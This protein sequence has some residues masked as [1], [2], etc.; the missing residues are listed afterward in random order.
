MLPNLKRKK[1][2]GS[3]S[4]G[5][6][7]KAEWNGGPV[8]VKILHEKLFTSR[9]EYLAQFEAECKILQ[10]LQ[11]K[12]VV[13][14][15]EF[16]ISHTSPPML[17]TELLDCDLGK[18]IANCHPG[19]IPYSETVSIMLDVAEGLAYLHQQNPPI[20]HRDL[21]SKN[22]LLTKERQAKIADV[23]L[24]KVLPKGEQNYCSP[25]PGTPVYA[26]PE[27]FHPDYDPI[28]PVSRGRSRVEYDNKIDIFSLGITLLEVINGRL[29]SPKPWTPFTSDGRQIP[30]RERRQ[31]DIEMMGEHKLK[32]IVFYCIKDSPKKRPSAKELA[33][34][35]QCESEKEIVP[36]LGMDF[37]NSTIRLHD[38][39]FTLRIVDTAG[40][41]K[42]QSMVPQLIR[43]VQGIAIVYDVTNKSSFTKGVPR[44]HQFIKNCAPD[45]VSLIL[46]GNK[47][48]ERGRVITK[49]RG[50]NCAKQLGISY[51]ETS[52]KTGLNVE[53][54]FRII[55]NEIYGNLD[56]SDIDVYIS[57]RERESNLD[58]KS[59]CNC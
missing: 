52:A 31:S 46:V 30:E 12:N 57:S 47:T 38:R 9:N 34:L 21:A 16:I 55:A 51:I 20:V 15:L 3:G 49:K 11:H 22:I 5:S 48:E 24:A 6:V 1:L 56:L 33:E 4:F 10:N 59:S 25:V 32:D 14:L 26:A 7:Y 43:N 27:T 54:M 29:P 41:E 37:K 42:C 19:R 36:T 23:G 28:F 18:Y 17:I 40:Q 44:M 45:N 13:T 58:T 8:A 35:F 39:E 53:E 2:M 50:E